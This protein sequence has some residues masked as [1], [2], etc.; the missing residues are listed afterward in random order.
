MTVYPPHAVC[1]C[2]IK[3][4]PRHISMQSPSAATQHT[5]QCLLRSGRARV[6]GEHTITKQ[7]GAVLCCIM[8][9]CCACS[10][11]TPDRAASETPGTSTSNNTVIIEQ[12]P[13]HRRTATAALDY[14]A[15]VGLVSY[16][17]YMLEITK[18][19]LDNIRATMDA[20]GGG[21][22]RGAFKAPQITTQVCLPCPLVH[23]VLW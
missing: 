9:H 23:A 8:T 6:S 1:L 5:V 21:R 20:W 18:Q 14:N 15:L 13:D 16:E 12:S 22:G 4:L 3:I 11:M 19:H 17:R 10:E 7:P 2:R